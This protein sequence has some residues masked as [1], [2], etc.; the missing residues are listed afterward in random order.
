MSIGR[1][2]E[3]EPPIIF[4]YLTFF[5]SV[6]VWVNSEAHVNWESSYRW[7]PSPCLL[8]LLFGYMALP[9]CQA[10]YGLSI[11]LCQ[12]WKVLV[13]QSCFA[14]SDTHR[15]WNCI[16]QVPEF[17]LLTPLQMSFPILPMLSMLP[18]LYVVHIA[19]AVCTAHM[20]YTAHG[21]HISHVIQATCA[22]W[23][24]QVLPMLL[25][26]LSIFQE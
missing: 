14:I 25:C 26:T 11:R 21:A 1:N 10:G 6:A 4:L 13:L 19:H 5:H 15:H 18:L 3:W 9:S 23:V 20:T 7:V 17:V 16:W 2:G 22:A 8:K 24:A 12:P